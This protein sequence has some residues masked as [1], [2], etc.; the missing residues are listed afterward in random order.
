MKENVLGRSVIL[1]VVLLFSF[2][3]KISAQTWQ[4]VDIDTLTPSDVFVIVDLYSS[5]AMSNDRGTTNPP[6]ATAITLNGDMSEIVGDVAENLKWNISGNA[7]DGYTF[8]PNGD[9]SKWLYC[10]ATNN[11]VRV[12]TNAANLFTMV[13]DATNNENF[14]HH[15]GTNRYIGVYSSQ[16]W[17]CYATVHNNIKNTKTRFFKYTEVVSSVETPVV[18]PSGGFYFEAPMVEISCESVGAEIYYTLDGSTPDNNSIHYTGPFTFTSTTMVKAI[19]YVGNEP[20]NVATVTYTLPLEIADI[21]TLRTQATGSTVYRLSGEA[22]VS[23]TGS[24]RNHKYIQDATGAILID[25]IDGVITSEYAAGDGMTGVVGTLTVFRGMLEFVPSTDPGEATSHDNVLTPVELELDADFEEY[26]AQLVR[27]S[28]V[29]VDAEGT[30][31]FNTD[32]A[33]ADHDNVNIRMRYEEGPFVGAAIPTAPQNITAVVYHYNYQSD[34]VYNLIPIAMEEV[35]PEPTEC[36]NV[37]TM[38]ACTAGLDDR[39]MLFTSQIAVGDTACTLY[40][41]GFVYSTFNMM[42]DVDDEACTKVVLGTAIEAETEFSYRL[43]GLG[44]DTYYVRAFATNEVGTGYSETASVQQA[45][46]EIYNVDFVVNGYAGWDTVSVFSVFEGE[47]IMKF[48]WL[49]DCENLAFAGWTLQPFEGQTDESPVLY[50]FFEPT[51]DTTFYAVFSKAT[52][53][54]E[55][56]IVISRASFAETVTVYGYDDQWTAVS[57]VTGTEI[58]GWCDLYT[59]NATMQMRVNTPYESHPY[60][61]TAMPGIISSITM[62]A[63]GGG[64]TRQWTPWLSSSPLTKEN[65]EDGISLETKDLD[66]SSSVMWEMYPGMNA[67]YFYLALSGGATYIDSIVVAY[68]SA[69]YLYTMLA[70]DTVTID[71]TICEGMTY[72]ENGFN[73]GEEGTHTYLQENYEFCATYY[74]LNLS[75]ET[76]D[77]IHHYVDTCD[78]YVLGDEEYSN[79]AEVEFITPAEETYGCPVVDEW[80][81]TIRHSSETD[82]EIDACDSYTWND[83]TYI[84][85]GIY[86][87]TFTNAE[88]CDSVVTLNLTVNYG[89]HNVTDTTVCESFTWHGSEYFESDTYIYEYDN[90]SGCPSADTLHLT[91][92]YSTHNVTDTTVCGSYTWNGETYTLSG[93]YMYNYLTDNCP[94]TDTLHITVNYGVYAE[95]MVDTCGTEFYWEVSGT[96]YDHSDTYYYYGENANGCEDTTV[97]VLSL[98]QSATTEFNAQICE[99]DTYSQNGFNVSESGDYTLPLETAYGCDSTV[100]LHLTVGSEAITN[101]NASICEG[102]DYNENGFNIIA[103]AAGEYEYSSTIERPGTCDSVVVLSLTVNI[104]TEGDTTAVACSSFSWYG[105]NLTESG[106]YTHVL[107]NAAGCDSTVTLHLTINVPTEGDTTATACSSFSW[108]GYANL[109]ES[110]D[111]TDVLTNAAGCD[112]TVTLHLTINVPTEGDTSAVACG[113]FDWHGQQLTES[114]DYTGIL[115]NVAGCDSTITLHLTINVPTEGDTTAVA[116]GSFDW[117]GQQ[118]TESGDYTDVLTNAAGCDSTVTLHLTINVPTEGDT[119][120]VA[121]GSFNWHGYTNLTESGDYTAVLTNAAGCDST[122]TLHLTIYQPVV[123][124]P[125]EVT[126]CENDLPYHYVNGEIDTTFEVGTPNLSTV[127]YNLTTVHGCDSTVTLHLT[128]NLPI[129]VEIS[130]TA[131]SSYSW[132]DSIYTESGDYV[133]TFTDANGCDSVVTLHLTVITINTE[134]SEA[135]GYLTVTPQENAT[136]QWIDCATNAPIEGETDYGYGAVEGDFACVITIGECVDTTE[137]WHV[138]VGVAEHGMAD[139]ILYPNPTT[140]IVN[141]RLTPETCTLKPEIHLFDIYG[142]RLQIMAV[143]AETIQIDLSRYATGVYLVKLVNDGKVIATGKV[144]KQ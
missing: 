16:D 136:Y 46:P 68:T 109:T 101:I 94:S 65:H 64:S 97:L 18:T 26:E 35:V 47:P 121:C 89:T 83:T 142:R 57:K 111:Y 43:A 134:I 81:I 40:E 6:T 117:H 27:V 50:D 87:Q 44:F 118:L 91:V 15:S 8:F 75:V 4:Q 1:L 99:G 20:S 55:D 54:V 62:Y 63:A 79:S 115:T 76:R 100:I 113:S 82:F 19:A 104:P 73:T 107:T 56:E 135:D 66:P 144:V 125:V 51:S 129:S 108:H 22:V 48:P 10:T 60:N 90:E 133:Q 132:N 3:G 130:D 59:N 119:T 93:T 95:V 24:Y 5:C 34:N 74:V 137:C 7:T 25:D 139:I 29:T 53:V 13:Y 92:N 123:T 37:P 17:R 138:Y 143:T 122:V 69:D 9:H 77:T 21:A 98:H 31:A 23:L 102:E 112:S 106:D 28:N 131:C 105:E 41:Y 78:L 114:G 126:I 85:S 140:G 110:G 49:S 67:T 61:V 71:Q 12:G 32:Y 2:L 103:P 39:D 88:G 52:N 80:H 38:G 11:G 14:L 72:N 128:I 124:E 58:T 116:C 127:T 45:E 30:F 86:T 70:V 42:P 36:E 84:E 141:I 96:S 120:A 33:I